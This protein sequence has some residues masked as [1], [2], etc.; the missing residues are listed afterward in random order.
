MDIMYARGKE[1]ITLQVGNVMGVSK[2]RY[3]F[4][5]QSR[6]HFYFIKTY[7]HPTK[8]RE[9]KHKAPPQSITKTHSLTCNLKER[10]SS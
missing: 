8:K 1:R 6:L 4:V 5:K 7:R 2:R 3:S 9:E 10:R